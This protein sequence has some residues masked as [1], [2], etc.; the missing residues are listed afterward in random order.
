MSSIEQDVELL[1]QKLQQAETQ[2]KLQQ[3]TERLEKEL[4]WEYNMDMIKKQIPKATDAT[5]LRSYR[6]GSHGRSIRL[7]TNAAKS[8]VFSIVQPFMKSV[9]ICLER[10]ERT[11]KQQQ[12]KIDNLENRLVMSQEGAIVEVAPRTAATDDI[13]PS[14]QVLKHRQTQLEK[15]LSKNDGSSLA[16]NPS[17]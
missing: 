10:L 12:E 6:M 2:L 3:E 1:R 13:V 17:C 8:A 11:I 4:S 16:Q 14:I 5:L 15:A 7:P 9:G